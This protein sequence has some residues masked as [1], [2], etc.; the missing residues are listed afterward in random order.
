MTSTPDLIR[1]LARDLAPVRRL[2]PPLLR[3][4][5]WLILGLVVVALL[6][7]TQGVRSDLV[8]RLQNP[9][10]TGTILG[11]ILTAIASAVAAF[12]LSLPD[13]SRWWAILPLPPLAL[14]FSHVGYQC[15]TSWIDLDPASMSIGETA[16]C[17]ATLVLTSLPLSLALLIM[18]RHAATLRPILVA[19]VGSLSV[20]AMTVTAL[21]LCH[22]LDAS[23]LTIMW[24]LG[25]AIMIV[26]LLLA[27][28]KIRA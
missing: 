1:S 4:S 18:L 15:L 19:I 20:A 2:R 26:G 21:F 22:I 5:L 17:F 14:W 16:R 3:A 7:I 28:V 27:A 11:T 10:F 6:A 8:T 12:M 24:N 25:T 9:A 13:R 23:V